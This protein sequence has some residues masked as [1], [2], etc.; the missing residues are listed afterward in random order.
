[1]HVQVQLDGIFEDNG[2]WLLFVVSFLGLSSPQAE[3][4]QIEVSHNVGRL[5]F[6]SRIK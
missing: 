2:K 3:G 4:I 5:L 1:M 6:Y